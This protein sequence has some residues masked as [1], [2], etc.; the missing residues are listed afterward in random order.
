LNNL[1]TGA[2]VINPGAATGAVFI[3]Y[4]CSLIDR[5]AV[6][7][8]KQHVHMLYFIGYSYINSGSFVDVYLIDKN[9]LILSLAN[10]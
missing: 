6:E 5:E 1:L 9:G 2:G 7:Q 10:K 8:I 3:E 4:L